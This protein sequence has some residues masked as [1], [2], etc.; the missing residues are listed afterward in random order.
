MVLVN[1]VITR[2]RSL[3][4]LYTIASRAL[5]AVGTVKTNLRTNVKLKDSHGIEDAN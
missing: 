1:M 4:V 5:A 2:K 3:T